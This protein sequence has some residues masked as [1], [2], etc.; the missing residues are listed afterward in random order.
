MGI[1]NSTLADS[2]A[3]AIIHI[4]QMS[5]CPR[6][7]V[8]IAPTPPPH[9]ISQPT[10][11]KFVQ[12]L[13]PLARKLNRGFIV[14]TIVYAAL[15]LTLIFG[16]QKLV[17]H[18]AFLI[19][20]VAIF[21]VYFAYMFYMYEIH[22]RNVDKEI[23][24]V[25]K[26]RE[27]TFLEAGYEMKYLMQ[28]TSVCRSR[29]TQKSERI[30]AFYSISISIGTATG[31]SNNGTRTAGGAVPTHS[32]PE[33]SAPIASTIADVELGSAPG[34]TT[35]AA[36]GTASLTDRLKEDAPMAWASSDAD[37]DVAGMSLAEQ[38]KR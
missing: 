21:A 35:A 38:L 36:T 12:E 14:S 27:R 1:F 15:C 29:K 18:N 25:M 16:V 34:T 2:S 5:S 37:G 17:E 30:I 32:H 10:W 19:M 13:D 3:A 26:Q 20:L 6:G 11:N 8:G 7:N 33:P 31:A 28:H 4:E 9:N 24:S 23:Q 22:N